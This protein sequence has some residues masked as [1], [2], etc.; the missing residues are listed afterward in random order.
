MTTKSTTSSVNPPSTPDEHGL[1]PLFITCPKG[2]EVLLQDELSRL[3]ATALKQTVGGVHC[4]ASLEIM[5]QICLWSGLANRVLLSLTQGPVSDSD[6]CYQLCRN[7]PW[8]KLFTPNSTL[9]VSFTGQSAFMRN[10]VYGAQLIKDGIVDHLRETLQERCDVD[11]KNPDCRVVARL[12]NG[13]LSLFY[14]LSGH[15][16]HQRGYRTQAGTA[17]IK[18]NLACALLIRA[19]WP[20][21]LAQEIPNSENNFSDNSQTQQPPLIDPC[22]G[23]GTLLIEAA[24]MATNKAPGLDRFDFGFLHWQGHNPGLWA[25]LQKQALEKHEQALEKNHPEFF[26]FDKDPAVLSIAK[27]NI[28]AAGFE[29]MIQLKEQSLSDFSLP[30]SCQDNTGLIIANPPYGERLE[31]SADLIP[32]YQEIGLALSQQANGW[33]AAIFT[34]DPMLAKSTGL[35]SYKQ[36]PLFNGTIPCQLYLFDLSAENRSSLTSVPERAQMILNR[37]KKNTKNL[38][39][40]R[41]K[42]QIEA[43]RIYDADIPEYACA[44]DIY[45]E[46]A[47]VQE[48]KAPAEIPVEKTEQRLRDLIQTIPFALDIPRQQ[49]I[50]KQRQKQKGKEQY[51]RQDITQH[52]LIIR[53]G[54][55]KFIVNC[56]DYL[57]TGL[58]LDHRLL[59][60]RLFETAKG[61][62]V[63]NLFCYTGTAS[64][65]AA[66]GGAKITVNV[67]LS[68]TYLE[69]AKDNFRLN[70]LTFSRHQFIQADCLKWIQECTQ[71]FDI[72]FLDPPSFSNSK[73]MEGT[74]DIQRDHV[75]LINH[76]M[77]QLKPEGTLYFS[78]NFKKFK[79]DPELLNQFRVEDINAQTIDKDFSRNPKIHRCYSIK[80]NNV[81]T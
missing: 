73:R 80:R 56:K 23:S 6:A 54:A 55:A 15:S 11:T 16:L 14:D 7:Y 45:K 26:G 53:E 8:S 35:R 57:D 33:Q 39:S 66:M 25:S 12:H 72:I 68:R 5:Y 31:D 32:L 10:T 22:C 81:V 44:I 43:Y 42:N 79:I 48:Y 67:D 21:M 41:R 74:L 28:K 70:D 60:R 40:W 18:E 61:L 47:V 75:T 76:C 65:Q 34:S 24:M 30:E 64:V 51:Q 19:G 27:R 50:L 13:K 58:F 49:I 63:L 2:I 3:G 20:K 9:A 62:E 38:S 77:K 29:G 69:W 1:F 4:E 71:Q 17:P 52:Q 37:L 59:R 78:T 36:Y 46:W